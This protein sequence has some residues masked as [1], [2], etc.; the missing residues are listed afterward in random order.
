VRAATELLSRRKARQSLINFTEYSYDRY[1]AGAHHRTI[2]E[3]LERVMRRDIDRLMLLVAPRHGKTELASRRYPAF[4]LGNHPTRQIIA[5]S[6]SESFATDVGREV[7]NIIKDDPYRRLFPDVQLAEDSQASGRW[8]TKQGGIFY[9]VGVGSQI[10][11]KGADEFI[12]DDP[13]GSMADAQSE[14]ERKRVIEWYQG[15]VYNRLQPG[16][17]IILINHRMHEGDLSGYLLEQQALGGDKWEVIELPAIQDDGTAL[18]PEAYPLEA[19]ERIKRNTLPRYWSALFQQDPQPDEGT[20]FKREWFKRYDELPAVNVYG[21]SDLAVT[22]AGGDYTE[23]AIW[24]VGADSTIY[25][26][27]WW[28]G[29]TN[30]SEWI[31]KQLD[32]VQ[33]HKPLTW[34]SEGGVIRRAIESILDKR[35]SERKT[36]VTM[37]WVPSIHDKPTR[38]RAFQALCANGKVAFPKAPW[39]D[40]VIDQLIRF[41]AGKHD[42]AVDACSLIGRAVSD[43]N[44]AVNKMAAAPKAVD[45]YTQHRTSLANRS[46]WKTA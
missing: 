15:S 14:V 17:A 24:G 12:I 32:L 39:A 26:I 30:A 8:H 20:F 6:A 25:A 35:M 4:C 29:Q 10:L 38:A 28:R 23:H 7:R 9:A 11:G 16:G 27:D 13:F 33:K 5:A 22:D 1:R 40:E 46:N 41:P 43:T 21:T 45:R 44:S 19:L 42:D 18:W 36:W 37:E 34:F 3:Q 31:E 2:A